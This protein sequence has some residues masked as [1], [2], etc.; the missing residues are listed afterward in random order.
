MA[1]LTYQYIDGTTEV[2]DFSSSITINYPPNRG[3]NYSF[4]GWQ[5][6]LYD[7]AAAELD[8]SIQEWYYGGEE[9][10]R[11]AYLIETADYE[12][13]TTP[14]S[15]VAY[16]KTTTGWKICAPRKKTVDGWISN[17]TGKLKT[18]NGWINFYPTLVLEGVQLFT[19][20][21]YALLDSNG[22]I[23]TAKEG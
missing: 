19:S 20:D 1:T 14:A 8:N 3:D 12:E 18:V 11:Y 21:G 22:A 23:L 13:E 15:A 2:I 9:I 6:T 10:Y 17:F 4:Y 7:S 16:I 5:N